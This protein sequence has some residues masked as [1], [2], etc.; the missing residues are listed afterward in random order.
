MKNAIKSKT[1]WINTIVALVAVLSLFTPLLDT[2]VASPELKAQIAQTIVF[3]QGVLNIV[4]RVFFTKEPIN[5][6]A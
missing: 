4:L 1:I 5:T 3:A 6:D 2:W